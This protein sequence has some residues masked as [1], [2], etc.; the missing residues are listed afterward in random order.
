METAFLI[1]L[2][3]GFGSLAAEIN[4]I[5]QVESDYGWVSKSHF[6]AL[7]S[8]QLY[9]FIKVI[10]YWRHPSSPSHWYTPSADLES[11][12]AFSI[13]IIRVRSRIMKHEHD[14]IWVSNVSRFLP[15]YAWYFRLVYRGEVSRQKVRLCAHGY[16][17]MHIAFCNTTDCVFPCI[18]IPKPFI[19]V[20]PEGVE[21][22]NFTIVL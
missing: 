10:T 4:V 1:V 21:L 18:A 12:V 14:S 17:K 7:L 20:I 15:R 6:Q 13:V 22:A 3:L 5:L 2:E 8:F 9:R 16:S 19:N 11:F